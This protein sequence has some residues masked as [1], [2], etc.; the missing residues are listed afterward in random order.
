MAALSVTPASVLKISGSV[1]NGAA[2]ATVTAGQGAYF[3]AATNSYKPAQADGTAEEV[4]AVGIFLNGAATGQP[5][6]VQ[7]SGVVAIGATVV[8][9]EVYAVGTGAGD[10]LPHSELANPN[11][12]CLLAVGTT[13][14]QLTLNIFNAGVQVPA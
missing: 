3:D 14:A 6:Q 7:T 5:V 1:S 13:A 10:I 9:G 4:A 2:G 11:R 8:V 12:V